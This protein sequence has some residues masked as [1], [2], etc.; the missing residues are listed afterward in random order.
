MPSENRVSAREVVQRIKDEE[1]RF[2]DLKFVDLF[3]T[4][5]HLTVPTEVVDEGSF[6]KGFSF[7]GSEA[8]CRES[9]RDAGALLTH[10]ERIG[11]LLEEA[12]GMSELVRLEVHTSLLTPARGGAVEGS[13]AVFNQGKDQPARRIDGEVQRRGAGVDEGHVKDQVRIINQPRTVH[14]GHVNGDGQAF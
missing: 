12:L 9:Y 6:Q 13:Q 10:L 8:H 11:P 14:V 5:Q 7:D 3:G 4:L 1:I 2:L